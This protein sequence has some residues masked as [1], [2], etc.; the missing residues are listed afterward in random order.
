MTLV[1]CLIISA[2]TFYFICSSRQEYGFDVSDRQLLE[3]NKSRLKLLLSEIELDY[4]LKKIDEK[5]YESSKLLYE[6][7]LL[8]VLSKLESIG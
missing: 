4:S 6:R 1:F 8:E 5:D 3:E 2:L 7:E